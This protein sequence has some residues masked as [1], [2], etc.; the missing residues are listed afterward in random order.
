MIV[1]V[2]GRPRIIN[3][4]ADS[5]KAIL[6]AYNPSNEGGTGDRRRVVWRCQSKWQSFPSLTHARRMALI[7]YDHKP[8]ETEN[9]AFGNMA[10]KPQFQFGEGLSYTTFTYSDLRLGKSAISANEELPV[11]VTVT[12]SGRRAGK[13]AV[14]ALRQRSRCVA[15][16]PKQTTA[17]LCEGQSRLPA[18]AAR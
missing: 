18:R 2:E 6:M 16:A 5:A 13:E 8:F 4:I 12:N 14:L 7:N 17:A 3:R 15:L 9:T 10:F 1:L 11:S